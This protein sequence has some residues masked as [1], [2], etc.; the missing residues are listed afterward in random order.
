MNFRIEI[1][2]VICISLLCRVMAMSRTQKLRSSLS[3]GVLEVYVLQMLAPT[4][5]ERVVCVFLG[6]DHR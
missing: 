1:C 3:S 6:R 5:R 4:V 2:S